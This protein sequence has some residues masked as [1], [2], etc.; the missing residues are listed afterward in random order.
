MGK[1]IFAGF[2]VACMYGLW[3]I[4]SALYYWVNIHNSF[5]ASSWDWVNIG[6]FGVCALLLMLVGGVCFIPIVSFVVDK[7]SLGG[8]G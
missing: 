5:W 1:Y 8:K 4:S 7:Y 6:L 2:G 3:H